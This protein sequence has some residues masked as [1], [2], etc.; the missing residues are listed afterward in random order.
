MSSLFVM[1]TFPGAHPAV[2]GMYDMVSKT[3]CIET[4]FR[5]TPEMLEEMNS[6]CIFGANLG[7]LFVWKAHFLKDY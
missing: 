4:S 1:F 2:T 7:T 5:T 3:G 6:R